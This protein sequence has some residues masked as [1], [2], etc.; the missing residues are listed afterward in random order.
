MQE[1]EETLLEQGP[2]E[3]GK[4]TGQGYKMGGRHLIF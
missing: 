4:K 2:R 1:R 3:L